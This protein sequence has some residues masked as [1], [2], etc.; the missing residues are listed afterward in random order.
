MISFDCSTKFCALSSFLLSSKKLIC[1]KIKIKFDA[2]KENEF[3]FLNE[4]I[5]DLFVALLT[6]NSMHNIK[7]PFKNHRINK[8]LDSIALI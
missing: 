6:F 4:L 1:Y 3:L 7:I 8:L 2:E 5:L